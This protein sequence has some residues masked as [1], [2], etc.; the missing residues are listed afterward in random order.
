MNDYRPMCYR[1]NRPRACCLCDT[2]LPIETRTQFVILIHP[3]EF[4]RIK[5]NTGRL[6]HLSLPNSL[7]L[8]GIDF[9]RHKAL[10]A[11]LDDPQNHCVILYPA[12]DALPLEESDLPPEGKRLVIILIDAT[13]ASARPIL[14]QSTNLHAL[15]RI[16]FRHGGSSAYGFKRQ[17][18]AEA[19]STIESTHAV[20]KILHDK[21]IEAITPA[22]LENFLSPF[23]KMVDFQRRFN[24]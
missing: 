13:W 1:C 18:F 17:P 14:R 2:I 20:L 12:A 3:K 11:I 8:C 7:L 6:T 10:N 5:N 15:P 19:L 4:K 16:T 22:Q 24:P 21:G 9:S 23:H